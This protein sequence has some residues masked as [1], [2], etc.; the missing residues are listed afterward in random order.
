MIGTDIPNFDFSDNT[1]KGGFY[2]IL[3]GFTFAVLALVNRRNA[4]ISDSIAIA[5]YQNFFAAIFLILPITIMQI[6]PPQLSNLP[7]LIFLGV[8]CTALAHTL[9]IKSLICIK[10]QTAAVI[11]GLEPVYGIIFAFFMLNEIPEIRTLIGGMII[12]STTIFAGGR[13]GRG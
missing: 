2:G 4:R 11:A 8:V 5:F 3:S 6:T 12:I 13:S 10:A 9:F 1:T 7:S